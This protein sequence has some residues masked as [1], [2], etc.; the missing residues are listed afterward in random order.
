MRASN[1]LL[2]ALCFCLVVQMWNAE[3]RRLVQR[4]S[5]LTVGVTVELPPI[6]LPVNLPLPPIGLPVNL[7]LPPIGLPVNLPLPPILSGSLASD[8]GESEK[9]GATTVEKDENYNP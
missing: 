6:G 2:L 1:V 3:A 4:R 5:D 7:P 8:E 9:A